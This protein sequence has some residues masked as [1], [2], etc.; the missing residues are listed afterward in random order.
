MA[1]HGEPRAAG[2]QRGRASVAGRAVADAAVR[3]RRALG[4]G[5][6]R[7]FGAA[8][9]PAPRAH[10]GHAVP[11]GRRVR[12]G[13]HRAD[14]RG[15]PGRG[16]PRRRSGGRAR[17][18]SGRRRRGHTQSTRGP[19]ETPGRRFETRRRDASAVSEKSTPRMAVRGGEPVVV[20][21]RRRRETHRARIRGRA[22]S[23]SSA[24]AT[25]AG[26]RRCRTPGA[27]PSGSARRR[28]RRRPRPRGGSRCG[29][30]G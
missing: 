20:G 27:A 8:R 19:S 15:A 12:R 30:S 16:R 4:D 6:R 9:A 3:R 10:R 23:P 25:R 11:P 24:R 2:K 17:R 21:E 5:Q 13:V 28:R 29:S 22:W 18:D 1:P 7:S 14:R 26:S